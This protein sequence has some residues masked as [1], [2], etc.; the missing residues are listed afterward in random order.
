MIKAA[1][2]LL[3]IWLPF[4]GGYL[5]VRRSLPRNAWAP[6]IALAFALLFGLYAWAVFY[7]WD[8]L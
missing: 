1:A 4:A 5:V 8:W 2:V 7:A 3:L 6:A